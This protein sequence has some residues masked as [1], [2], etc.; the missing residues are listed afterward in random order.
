MQNERCKQLVSKASDKGM[1]PEEI[2]KALR[3]KGMFVSM[4]KIA[5]ENVEFIL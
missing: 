1:R 4:R 5:K 3:N 2:Y